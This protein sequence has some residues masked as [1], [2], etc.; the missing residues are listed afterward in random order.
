MEIFPSTPTFAA[1]EQESSEDRYHPSPLE[2]EIIVPDLKKYFT[3]PKRSKDRKDQIKK[4]L[5]RLNEVHP[6]HWSE[7]SVRVWFT[8]NQRKYVDEKD[9]NQEYYR[10]E[11]R[12][13]DETVPRIPIAAQFGYPPWP[14]QTLAMLQPPLA[15]LQQQQQ[16]QAIGVPGGQ[17]PESPVPPPSSLQLPDDALDGFRDSGLSWR[18]SWESWAQPPL[19]NLPADPD[20]ADWVAEDVWSRDKEDSTG[21]AG[22]STSLSRR[23]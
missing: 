21:T 4:T 18:T 23:G 5:G 22:C 8:N 20:L 2:K 11:P 15:M 12:T 3:M 1:P 7:R 9:V 19:L 10:K 16:Q 13:P 17:I 14:P 6:G